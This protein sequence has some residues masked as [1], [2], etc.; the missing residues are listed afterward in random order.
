MPV[1]ESQSETTRKSSKMS[2]SGPRRDA[3]FREMRGSEGGVWDSGRVI[4]QLGGVREGAEQ[5]WAHD[6]RIR[7]FC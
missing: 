7:S 2:A 4:I 6:E 3:E 5:A 1:L